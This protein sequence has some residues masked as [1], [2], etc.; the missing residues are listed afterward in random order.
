MFNFDYETV[1]RKYEVSK[2]NMAIY[3]RKIV[4]LL[5]CVFNSAVEKCLE[6]GKVECNQED[7][8]SLPTY[9]VRFDIKK[10]ISVTKDSSSEN[11]FFEETKKF[12]RD[13]FKI[14]IESNYNGVTVTPNHIYTW[15]TE[16][17]TPNGIKVEYCES[18]ILDGYR[19]ILTFTPDKFNLKDNKKQEET[20]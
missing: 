4:K 12:L 8:D 16:V 3:D 1:A 20:F 17:G 14:L 15:A 11:Y 18:E 7:A 5:E 13:N 2:K 19:I 10:I 9:T 6:T